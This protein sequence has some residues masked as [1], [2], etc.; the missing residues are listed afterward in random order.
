MATARNPVQNIAVED[1]HIGDSVKG[2]VII[3]I[4]LSAVSI[5]SVHWDTNH[6]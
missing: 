3:Y 6:A 2:V 5:Q 4:L 1:A